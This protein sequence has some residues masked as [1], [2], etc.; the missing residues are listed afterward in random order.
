LFLDET[1][2]YLQ[3]L[4]IFADNLLISD[5]SSYFHLFEMRLEQLTFT[6]FLAALCV[7]FYHYATMAPYSPT[8]DPF[9]RLSN[10]FVS[11]F[12]ILSGFVLM[13]AYYR[14]EKGPI[15]F[16]KF[17][18]N[19]FL[20]IYPVYLLAL[21]AMMTYL[22]LSYKQFILRDTILSLSLLQA[23][24]PETP[25]VINGAGWSLSVEAFFYLLFPFL[26]NRIYYKSKPILGVLGCFVF[27]MVNQCI[28]I[29]YLKSSWYDP[30]Y[31]LFF[32]FS[33]IN[34][35]NEFVLGNGAGLAYMLWLKDK[36]W[37]LDLPV[38]IAIGT[39]VYFFYFPVSGCYHNGLMGF[40]FVP[41][42]LLMSINNAWITRIF[43]WPVLILLGESS[44]AIYILQAPIFRA[45][46]IVLHRF[47]PGPLI[48]FHTFMIVLISLSI[49]IY[50]WVE[51]PIQLHWKKK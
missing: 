50:L 34:H 16:R 14:P 24:W 1:Q 11:Y 22:W 31:D 8:F 6:R 32:F 23:W 19:R 41:L 28:F 35:I 33:P 13:V 44:Y 30:R 7:L 20:R 2:R 17:Y 9:I 25:L 27:W 42:I 12:F 18:W 45:V 37:S 15:S 10:T 46:E 40:V 48:M 43:H 47:N 49:S 38:I 39:V 21:L 51:K 36:K 4:Y 26:L 29:L 5:K 3:R